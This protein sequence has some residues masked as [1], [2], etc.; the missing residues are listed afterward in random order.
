MKMGV[1][2]KRANSGFFDAPIAITDLILIF[3]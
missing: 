3:I 1:R 2:R